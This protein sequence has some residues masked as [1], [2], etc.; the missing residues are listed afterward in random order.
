MFGVFVSSYQLFF[1]DCVFKL[2]HDINDC[3]AKFFLK[4]YMM[5]LWVLYM[6]LCFTLMSI[7]WQQNQRANLHEVLAADRLDFEAKQQRMARRKLWL[8]K[9]Q[10]LL[11]TLLTYCS[12]YGAS[13]GG[14]ACIKMELILLLQVWH[15]SHKI[16]ENKRHVTSQVYTYI[17]INFS[18]LARFDVLSVLCYQRGMPLMSLWIFRSFSRSV[19]RS[20]CYHP[21]H[22]PLHYHCCQR[23]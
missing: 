20:S 13:G 9:N 6:Y 19:H 7:L 10:Q 21:F 14:L 3:V 22:S 16:C 2:M 1:V 18:G 15:T 4:Y 17:C 23:V 12:M 8:K 11:R 5:I